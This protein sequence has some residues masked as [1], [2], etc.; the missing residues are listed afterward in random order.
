MPEMIE[1]RMV[2]DRLWENIEKGVR[3]NLNGPGYSNPITG[4]FVPEDSVLDY[5]IEILKG[6]PDRADDVMEYFYQNWIKEG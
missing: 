2:V 3:E 6:D 5:M 1:N 4:V